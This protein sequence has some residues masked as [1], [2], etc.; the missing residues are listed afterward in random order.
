MFAS[1]AT[2]LNVQLIWIDKC[3]CQM[4]LF[5]PILANSRMT[6]LPCVH[7]SIWFYS[8]LY[9]QLLELVAGIEHCWVF[10]AV[11]TSCTPLAVAE[12]PHNSL[13]IIICTRMIRK[14]RSDD[15][16]SLILV[17]I[18]DDVKFF[19]CNTCGTV[20]ALCNQAWQ[21]LNQ[22]GMCQHGSQESQSVSVDW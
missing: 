19:S 11:D 21:S 15:A 12:S 17:T 8:R 3:Q 22:W 13:L 20:C 18:A 16:S 9:K 5:Q 6:S 1:F 7:C 10:A 14:I 4:I 2:E